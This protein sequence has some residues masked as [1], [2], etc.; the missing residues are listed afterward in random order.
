M[1]RC[2]AK[3]Y[4]LESLFSYLQAANLAALTEAV[5]SLQFAA[6]AVPAGHPDRAGKLAALSCALQILC[7]VRGDPDVLDEALLAIREAVTATPTRHPDRGIRLHL[8]SNALLLRVQLTDGG[9]A[10]AEAVQ[11]AR[12]EIGRASCRERAWIS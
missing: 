5:A 9:T 6:E 7:E 1:D 12:I 2:S 10:L 11:A 3:S 8:L 4:D